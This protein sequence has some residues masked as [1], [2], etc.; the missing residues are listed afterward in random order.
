MKNYD[1]REFIATLK[2]AGELREIDKE[3]DWKLEAAA[4]AA[5]SAR[6]GGPALH[7]T[8]IKGYHKGYSLVTGMYAGRPETFWKRCAIA[9]GMPPDISWY[10]YTDELIRRSGQPIPPTIVSTGP[11]KENIHIGKEAN[12]LEFPIPYL[13]E[14]DGGR[15]L[16]LSDIIQRDPDSGWVNWGNYRMMVHSKDKLGVLLQ[17]GLGQGARI[18][19]QK[20]EAREKTMPVCIAIGGES[21]DAMVGCMTIPEGQNESDVAGA[22][23]QRPVE[24]VRAETNDLYVPANAEI[25][26]EGEVRPHERMGEGPFG[27]FLGFISGPRSPRPVIRV[28]AITHRNNPII[29]F[30]CEGIRWNDSQGLGTSVMRL[31]VLRVLR[32]VMGLPVKGV[33][34]PVELQAASP[35]TFAT[36]VPYPGYVQDF[37]NGVY[38]VSGNSNMTYFVVVDYD[39]DLT[40]SNE[41]LQEVV[42]K[43]HPAR[44]IIPTG[45]V[46]PR[47]SL[48]SYLSPAEKLK[49]ADEAD[50]DGRMYLDATSPG[51]WDQSPRPRTRFETFFPE[52]TQKFVLD[53]WAAMGFQEKPV[54][55]S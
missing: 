26:I 7:F 46:G 5:M 18:F 48:R 53:N 43:V 34:T 1:Y 47:S 6:V 29:P 2:E 13:H 49:A 36:K 22:L 52:E 33:Y 37:M 28:N 41:I 25:V 51:A 38:A 17:P 27:E 40:D 14:G 55:K 39:V 31:Y 12:L 15:Y 54:V 24:L 50:L 42:T 16:T 9:M 45:K 20:Y 21:V 35:V 23:M 3:V 11:C 8:N 30:V 44:D 19:F 4:I 32:D 10:D